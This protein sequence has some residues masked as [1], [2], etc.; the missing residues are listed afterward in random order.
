MIL[1]VW[2]DSSLPNHDFREVGSGLKYSYV[3]YAIQGG[4][5]KGVGLK[6]AVKYHTQTLIKEGDCIAR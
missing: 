4:R 6:I 1:Q 3:S 5:A 2:V